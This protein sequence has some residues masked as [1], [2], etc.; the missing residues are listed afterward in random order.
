[1]E[2]TFETLITSY[3]DNKIG[4]CNQFISEKLGTHLKTNLLALHDKK[5]FVE[6]GVGNVEKLLLDKLV[7]S[8]SIYWL[9]RMH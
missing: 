5:L 6:A 9:D 1:M 7:R 2:A 3:I 4:I 8:D